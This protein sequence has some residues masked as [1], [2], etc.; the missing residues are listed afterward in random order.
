MI[1]LMLDYLRSEILIFSMLR[2]KV[3]IKIIYLDLF[4]SGAW[5]YTF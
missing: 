4:I 2:L 3:L 1:D 5:P